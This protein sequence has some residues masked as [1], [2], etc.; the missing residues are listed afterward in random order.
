MPSHYLVRPWESALFRRCRR[1][2][3]LGARERGD[4]EPVEPVRVFDVGEALHDALDVYYFPGMWRWSREIVRP[5]AHQGFTKS[6]RRQRAAYAERREL[7]EQQQQDWEQVL[8]RGTDLLQNYL[9]WAVDLD[10]FT[11]VQVALQFDVIVPDPDHPDFGLTLPDGRDVQYRPRVDMIVVDEHELTW[12]AEHRVVDSSWAELDELLLDEQS[13]TRAWA[14]ERAFLGT[15]EGTIHTELRLGA[16][17]MAADGTEV[18]VMDGPGGFITQH[19][20]PQFRRTRIPRSPTELERR[21]IA[22]GLEA[23]DMIDPKLRIYPNPSR[24][25]CSGCP[26]VAPCL[27]TNQGR[28]E[29]RILEQ[30]YRKRD[31]PDFEPGRL[32]SVWGFV[33]DTY[34]V[35]EHRPRGR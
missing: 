5:M 34:R 24:A 1:A 31:R 21:G 35:A 26:Y 14:W 9:E 7:P 23:Q 25:H 30:S 11:P 3:D 27:A 29:Q 19:R 32:G 10:G 8:Q 28:D 2:W 16:P 20:S 33:P 12:L 17:D 22:L 6:M 15:I 18:Q 4:Y 13:L